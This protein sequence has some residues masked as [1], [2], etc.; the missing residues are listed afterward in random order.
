MW[1]QQFHGILQEL[2]FARTHSD[3]GVYHRQDDGGTVI[4]ILYVDD[5]TILGENINT[6]C[7]IKTTLSNHY[8][9]TNLGEIN[10]Y[11]RV[12]IKQNRSIK[13]LEIDQPRYVVEIVNR[14]G[15]SEVNPMRTPLP[16]GADVHL[17]KYDG[18]A[19][20]GDIKLYQ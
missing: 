2:G 18:K 7:Q 6:I 8:K 9:M 12:N 5:I 11:L 14:F 1:N 15:L 19:T 4:I 16:S 10:S 20:S 3:T 17:T 13:C